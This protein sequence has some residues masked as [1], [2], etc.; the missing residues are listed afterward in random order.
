MNNTGEVIS[1]VRAASATITFQH[2]KGNSLPGSLLKRLADTFTQ[3]SRYSEIRVILLQSS[4]NG[5]FCGGASF[6]ELL[7]IDNFNK[8]K[9][10][11]SGFANVILAM[12]NCPRIIITR[13]Q[14]KTVGGGVG[15]IAA[16]DYVIA[17][18]EASVKLS[19]LDLGIGPFV[20]GPVIER[21]IGKGAFSALSIDTE[22]RESEWCKVHGLYSE[23]TDSL[24]ALDEKIVELVK[25]L[26][27]GSPEAIQ[28]LKS[29]LWE[30]T[31]H[32][33]TLLSSR[34]EIS[35]RLVFSEFTRNY[36]SSFKKAETR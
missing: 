22:W 34:A 7:E 2:P 12:K 27:K 4:G 35:G 29:I 36:L 25:K 32:W 16:S 21:K 33:D 14:G 15:L 28:R 23:V 31:E 3:M 11:F 26:S 30:G 13:V 19:E 8:G 18:A 17:S 24:E 9:E 1:E 10:Y 5:P 20:V 6:D